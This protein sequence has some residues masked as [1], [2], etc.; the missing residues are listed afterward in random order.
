MPRPYREVVP[1]RRP[2]RPQ[3]T[4]S[5]TTRRAAL[6]QGVVPISTGE[7]EVRSDR[8]DPGSVTVLVN[9]VPSS[10]LDLGDPTRLSFE[11]MQQMAAAIELLPSGPLDAVHLGAGACALPRWLEAVRPGSRQL[12]VDVDAELLRLVR[13]WFELPRA[14]RLRLRA[15]DAREAIA[16]LP[17]ASVDVVVRDVFAPDVTPEHLTTV[18]FVAEV[19]RVLRPGGLYL[20]NCADRPPLALVRTEVATA[21]T[22]LADVALAAEPAQLKGRRYGN[23]VVLGTRTIEAGLDLGAARLARALRSLAVP[24]HLLHGPA[25]DAF[26]G[27]GVP[28][29]DHSTE[30]PS[31]MGCAASG[32]TDA[33]LTGGGHSPP[34]GPSDPG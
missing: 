10:Q 29:H 13:L 1:D 18:E 16:G 9:G 21:R 19:A 30:A 32:G 27:S 26:V 24:V 33:Q 5:T 12:A 3:R 25:L 4:R 31:P 15:Q 14:P 22:G 7:A 8:H 2:P 28:R 23:T 17:A 20:A 11:Y 34:A 6:P